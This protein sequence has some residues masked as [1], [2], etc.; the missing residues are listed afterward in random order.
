MYKNIIQIA[1]AEE[2][3]TQGCLNILCVIGP[4]PL[5]AAAFFSWRDEIA[6]PECTQIFKQSTK[7]KAMDIRM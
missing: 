7:Y 3:W 5:P 4:E 1:G 2:H 6:A